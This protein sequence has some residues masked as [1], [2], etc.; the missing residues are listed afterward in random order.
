[1]E[2]KGHNSDE[3]VSALINSVEILSKRFDKNEA[4]LAKIL[5]TNEELIESSHELNET[6]IKSNKIF[7]QVATGVKELYDKVKTLDIVTKLM[8][9]LGSLGPLLGGLGS[10][11]KK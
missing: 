9:N 2:S 1:M 7:E 10:Q 4:Q 11:P 6:V 3:L 5:E 8:G